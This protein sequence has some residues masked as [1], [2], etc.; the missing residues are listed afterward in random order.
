MKVGLLDATGEEIRYPGYERQSVKAAVDTP[1]SARLLER[2]TFTGGATWKGH[3]FV[4]A[5]GVWTDEQDYLATIRL[6]SA[7]R[8]DSDITL[9]FDLADPSR[10]WQAGTAKNLPTNCK[11]CNHF[12]EHV[13]VE[14][15]TN[16]E[17]ICRSCR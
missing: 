13:G 17:Y 16:G 8:I 3:A 4:A 10:A 5:L 14:H 15:L 7:Y 6:Q 2:V 9:T 1:G 12:N 11:K